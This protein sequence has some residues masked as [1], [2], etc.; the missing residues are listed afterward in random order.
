MFS[1]LRR[2]DL[3]IDAS[4]QADWGEGFAPTGH[5]SQPLLAPRSNWRRGDGD[6]LP[7]WLLSVH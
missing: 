2:H 1:G 5:F 3:R 6:A 4:L 7:A